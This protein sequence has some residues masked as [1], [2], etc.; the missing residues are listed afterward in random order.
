VTRSG[1]LRVALIASPSLPVP[2]SWKERLGSRDEPA[3]ECLFVVFFAFSLGPIFW[4]MT[5]EIIPLNVRGRGWRS[6]R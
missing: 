4:L 1:P 3:R 6:P 5:A 2:G